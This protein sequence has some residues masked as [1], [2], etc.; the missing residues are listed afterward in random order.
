MFTLAASDKD[1]FKDP[2]N[3]KIE[4]PED[5]FLD[6]SDPAVIDRINRGEDICGGVGIR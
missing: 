3:G 5:Q 2:A 1:T 6:L 4:I